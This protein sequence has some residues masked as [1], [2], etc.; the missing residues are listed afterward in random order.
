MRDVYL[1]RHS[2]TDPKYKGIC[3]G[4]SDVALSEAGV[5]AIPALV[6]QLAALKPERVVSS[7]AARC[8][9]VAEPLAAQLGLTAEIEPRLR[10]RDFGAWELRPW[11]AIFDETGDEMEGLMTDDW[12]PPGGESNAEL[13][14]RCREWLEGLP[15]GVTVAVTHGGPVAALVGATT[16]RPAAEWAELVPPMGSVTRLGRG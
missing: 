9:A 4:R 16:G 14:A 2:E 12:H 15:G 7:D 8:R 10:E 1:A 3:V 13:L 5:K 6:A 11:Q